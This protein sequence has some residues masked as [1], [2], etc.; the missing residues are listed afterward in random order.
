MPVSKPQIFEVS[1]PRFGR[2]FTPWELR[3]SRWFC[4]LTAM[5]YP[6][7]DLH[8]R[9]LYSRQSTLYKLGINYQ[10]CNLE[11]LLND[12]YD[13]VNRG[14]Y[15]ENTPITFL[16]LLVAQP[17][18]NK[19]LKV[20]QESEA[21]PIKVAQPTETAAGSVS[22]IIYIPVGVAFEETELRALV[23]AYANQTKTFAIKTYE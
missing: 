11:R 18:E 6:F 7:S 13:V 14:I 19:P 12:S 9:F 21:L 17:V 3:K 15:I 1:W 22:F 10:T 8:S 23:M 4:I 16:P 2:M 20:A 5:L